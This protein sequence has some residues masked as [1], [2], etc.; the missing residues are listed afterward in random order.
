MDLNRFEH[1]VDEILLNHDIKPT[2][3]RKTILHYL[4][5]IED[6]PSVEQILTGLAKRGE[7]ISR[8]TVYNVLNL[9]EDKNIIKVIAVNNNVK[10]YDINFTDHGHFICTNCNVIYDVDLPKSV[11]Y[12]QVFNLARD[13]AISDI[14]VVLRGIC[15]SCQK[16]LKNKVN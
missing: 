11:T 10:H 13:V 1:S 5:E 12:H 16:I 4:L 14:N 8:A 15:Q 2:T 7:K 6:H 9:L 3:Q